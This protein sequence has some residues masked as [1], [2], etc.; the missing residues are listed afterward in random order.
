MECCLE[1]MRVY[2]THFINHCWPESAIAD[3]RLGIVGTVCFS[4]MTNSRHILD[5]TMRSVLLAFVV[6]CSL[7]AIEAKTQLDAET[8]RRLLLSGRPHVGL[9]QALLKDAKIKEQEASLL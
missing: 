9:W 7:L 1:A 2:T 3:M 6:L 4:P 5:K 8:H